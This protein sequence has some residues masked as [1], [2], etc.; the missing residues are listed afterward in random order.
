MLRPYSILSAK[1][2]LPWIDDFLALHP[3]FPIRQIECS[4]FTNVMTE[5]YQNGQQDRLLDN[6]Q[7]AVALS[8]SFDSLKALHSSKTLHQRV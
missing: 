8:L 1:T 4:T 7:M 6:T 3:S 2:T 5:M